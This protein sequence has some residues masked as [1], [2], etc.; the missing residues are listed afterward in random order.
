MRLPLAPPLHINDFNGATITEKDSGITNGIV[1]KRGNVLYTTQRPSIDVFEDASVNVSDARGRAVYYW[2]AASDLY[3]LNNDTIYKNSHA[4]VVSTSPTAGT[5][6]CKFVEVGGVLVLL[7]AE[8]DQGFTITTGDVVTEITDTDFPPKQTPAVALAYGGAALDNYLFVL[9]E[10]GIIYNSNVNAPATWTALDYLEA[11]RAPDGG[12]YLGKHHD[13]LV[14][15]GVRTV[16]FFYDAANS[17]GSPLNRRQDVAYQIGCTSGESVW[18][19]GD[20]AFF[21]GNDFSGSLKVFTLENF[22][23][24]Q[25]STTSI[26]SLITQAI[27]KDGYYAN[28]CGFSASGHTF[29]VLNL[30]LTPSDSEATT[31][32]VYDDSTGLWGDWETTVNGLSKFPLMDWSIRTGVQPRYG[33]GIL[34][35]GDLISI[36]DNFTPQDTLLASTYV[37]TGYVQTGYVL[38]GSESGTAINMKIRLGQNDFGSERKKS[39]PRIRHTGDLTTTSQNLTFTWAK[40]NNASFNSGVTIDTSE[41]SRVN[42]IGSFRRINFDLDYSGTEQLRLEALEFDLKPGTN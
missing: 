40:E 7:D 5:K 34:F 15:Y 30:Y 23:I 6:K 36:N 37:T 10:D 32:L 26:D 38:A 19:E 39:L 1:E 17:S 18:E 42:R 9:G 12:Q 31:T 20:R 27:T 16:E 24:R 11:E 35:N 3:F 22:Q 8:N 41:F 33:E 28:G 4:S 29:Y 25:I 14:A 2:D 13:N 21:V